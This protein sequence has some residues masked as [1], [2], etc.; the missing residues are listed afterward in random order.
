VALTDAVRRSGLP[1]AVLDLATRR[2]V[3]VSDQA[4][5]L[6]AGEAADLRGW[7]IAGFVAD[8]PTG[9]LPL[10]A[11]GQLD[12]FEAPRRLRRTDGVEVPAYVWV[13]VLGSRRPARLAAAVLLDARV[14]LA[15][16]TTDDE[17]RLIGSVDENWHLERIS[18]EARTVL[19]WTAEQLTGATVLPAVHPG[20]LPELLTGLA[21]VQETGRDAAVRLRVMRADGSYVWTRAHLSSFDDTAGFL[22]T[23]RPMAAGLTPAADRVGELERR[24]AR[25]AAEVRGA[26]VAAG[27]ARAATEVPPATEL[28]G[29]DTL[30][31]REWEVLTEL[32]QG[33]RV[34]G[35]ARHLSLSEGTVRNHLSAVYRKLGVSSQAELLH[36]LRGRG[37][38][39]PGATL[40]P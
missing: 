35:I 27:L 28:P 5:A 23:L 26:G 16:G 4:A 37:D 29:L 2:V 21:H 7:P 34:A 12:G 6:V 19:G 24:L 30:T 18:E 25:I 22:F 39:G 14:P 11:T 36:L 8:P 3:A 17:W 15:V 20:D 1:V 10:L 9:G 32:A 13:H 38:Q 33:S 31:A 40:S